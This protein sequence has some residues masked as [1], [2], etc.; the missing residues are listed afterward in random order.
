[1]QVTRTLTPAEKL[2]FAERDIKRFKEQTSKF[3]GLAD[4]SKSCTE[5]Y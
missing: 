2:E 5:A 1:M 4:I 3:K